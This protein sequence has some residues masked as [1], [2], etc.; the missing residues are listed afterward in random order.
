MQ[1]RQN[2]RLPGRYREEDIPELPP[3]P[4]ALQPTIPFDPTLPPA[5][6]PTLPL[7]QSL[8]EKTQE[9]VSDTTL[10]SISSISPLNPETEKPPFVVFREDPVITDPSPIEEPDMSEYSEPSEFES[11]NGEDDPKQL[12]KGLPVS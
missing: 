10:S 2:R 8:P 11:W 1:L 3:K 4:T 7:N 5:A 6:F 12:R 9:T